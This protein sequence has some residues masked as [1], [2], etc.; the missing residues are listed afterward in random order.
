MGIV[1]LTVSFP[2]LRVLVDGNFEGW[3]IAGV[4]L[5]VHGYKRRK[6]VILAVGVLIATIK[7]QAVFLLLLVLAL[8]VLQT[9]PV[10]LWLK[11]LVVLLIVIIPCLIWRGEAWLVAMFGE[12]FSNYTSSLID[13]TLM[14]ALQRAGITTVLIRGGLWLLLLGITLYITLTGRREL[15]REKAGLLITA[16]LLTAPYAA[17]NSLL[18][19]LAIGIIPLF[20]KRPA[21]GGL[22]IVL[23]NLPLVFYQMDSVSWLAYYSTFS[24]L[25]LWGVLLWQEYQF[26]RQLALAPQLDAT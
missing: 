11:S 12:N 5:L 2:T 8:S 10:R 15:S 7:P 25:L 3:I 16:S 20:M 21:L 18:V 19:P 26:N 22:F 23:F 9:W 1:L 14:A 4:L 6:P 24:L 17:G 13:I